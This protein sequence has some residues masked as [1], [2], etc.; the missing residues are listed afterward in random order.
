VPAE[1]GL[2]PGVLGAEKST[3]LD[4]LIGSNRAC[5][6]HQTQTFVHL[7]ILALPRAD[8]ERRPVKSM[9]ITILSKIS[10][11]YSASCWFVRGF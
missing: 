7:I 8:C 2:S 3:H 5:E 1:S 11:R 10:N 4:C 6:M 9:G